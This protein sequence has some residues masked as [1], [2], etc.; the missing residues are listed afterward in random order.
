MHF[1]TP[2][3]ALAVV[4]SFSLALPAFAASTQYSFSGLYN[5]AGG[6]QAYTGVFSITDPVQTAVQP[7]NAA[8]VTQPNIAAVW[9]GTSDFFTGGADLQITFASGTVIKASTLDIVVN[10]TTFAGSGSPY[11]PGMSVQLFASAI[12]ITAPTHSVCATQTGVCGPD[13]DPLYQDATQASVMAT[14]GLYFAFYS[15][16]LSAT[17]G[18]PILDQA[19]KL[20]SGEATPGAGPWSP[21]RLQTPSAAVVR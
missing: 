19:F 4:A 3:S 9:S 16:P 5:S 15:A 13:D 1:R 17:P 21:V 10:Q 8:D 2:M 18:V 7:A 11:P 6:S 20:G 12:A 14:T